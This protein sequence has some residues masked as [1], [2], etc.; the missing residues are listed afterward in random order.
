MAVR[1]ERPP[2][3]DRRWKHHDDELGNAAKRVEDS[4]PGPWES[5]KG[6]RTARFIR[7][8]EKYLRSPKNANMRQP[9]KLMPWQKDFAESFLGGDYSEAILGMGR[10]GGKSTFLAT[11]AMFGLFESNQQGAPSIPIV[12]KTLGQAKDSVFS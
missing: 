1:I 5:W 8:V 2:K 4:S 9:L 12:A 7:F 6:S 11:L 3:L 10:G